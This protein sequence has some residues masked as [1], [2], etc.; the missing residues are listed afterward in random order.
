MLTRTTR[1][2]RHGVCK[3]GCSQESRAGAQ[4]RKLGLQAVLVSD[5]VDAEDD[6][7]LAL[8]LC[9]VE[10]AVLDYADIK[11]E[12]NMGMFPRLNFLP[13]RFFLHIP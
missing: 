2:E 8:L 5:G 6:S 12:A 7:T 4:V 1:Q 9:Y 3:F 13:S 10:L 11:H